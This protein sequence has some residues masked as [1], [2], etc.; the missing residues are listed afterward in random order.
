MEDRLDGNMCNSRLPSTASEQSVD[1]D[2][3]STWTS[4][5]WLLSVGC[6]I[7]TAIAKRRSAEKPSSDSAIATGSSCGNDCGGWCCSN[8]PASA[9]TSAS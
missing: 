4:R 6:F 1:S 8:K 7:T 9:L 5:T 3:R 2:V